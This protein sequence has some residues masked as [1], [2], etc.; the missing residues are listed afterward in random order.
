LY[1]LKLLSP[2]NEKI[3]GMQAGIV[4]TLEETSIM[5]MKPTKRSQRNCG[6]VSTINFIVKIPINL[7]K[8]NDLFNFI[9]LSSLFLP[10]EINNF[11]SYFL[12]FIIYF[13]NFLRK[14]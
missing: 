2:K 10:C 3:I 7:F 4:I 8:T 13:V 12:K 1:Y 11:R 14:T 5:I 6:N 9:F